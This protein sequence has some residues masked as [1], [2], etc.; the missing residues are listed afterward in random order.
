MLPK[1][2]S[3]NPQQCLPPGNLSERHDWASPKAAETQEKLDGKVKK[4][5]SKQRCVI[6]TWRGEFFLLKR[7][8]IIQQVNML[9]SQWNNESF[10]E[11]VDAFLSFSMSKD[12]L[13]LLAPGIFRRGTCLGFT[14]SARQ[15]ASWTRGV[16]TSNGSTWVDCSCL[17]LACLKGNEEDG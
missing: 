10:E 13:L 11:R 16:G 9:L 14:G 2:L 1:L 15:L 8:R 4:S 3:A 17:W 7:Y 5:R 6:A 12:V